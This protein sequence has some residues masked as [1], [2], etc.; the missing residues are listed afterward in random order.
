M[1]ALITASLLLLTTTAVALTPPE[2]EWEKTYSIRLLDVIEAYGN[3]YLCAGWEL[4]TGD[5]NCVFCYNSYGNLL[6]QYNDQVYPR[7]YA[8]ECIRQ[9]PDSTIVA[10][11]T[12]Y[13][14]EGSANAGIS[15]GKLTDSG[16]KIWTKV[17]EIENAKVYGMDFVI[18]PDGGFAV[19]GRIDPSEGMDQ[20]IILRTDAQGDTLWT[21]EWGWVYNDEAMSVLY[22]DNGLTVLIDG[23]ASGSPYEPYLIRYDMDGNLLWETNFPDWPGAPRAQIMCEA[24]DGGLLLMDNYWPTIMHTDYEGNPDWWFW[25]PGSDQPY[26][27]SLSTTMDGGILYG[28]EERGAPTG[29][30]SICG[31]IARYDSLGNGLWSDHVYNSG[32]TAIYSVRQLSHGGY[33]AAGYAY[34]PEN[35]NQAFLIKYAP[36][37]GVESQNLSPSLEISSISPNPFSSVTEIQFS[38]VETGDA[39]LTVYDLNGRVI[40]V[41]GEGVFTEGEHSLQWAPD[42]IASG[43][44][45]VRLTTADNSITGNVV[46]L[47]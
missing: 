15:I 27:H 16:D 42:E 30:K 9:L 8:T 28:G 26:G 13:Q 40:D 5:L 35:G 1:R 38:L 37:L 25:P 17:Y 39:S 34:T 45:L 33:I 21:R 6:W 2:I 41:L 10:V 22:I 31:I 44:Y 23:R 43:C 3:K 12:G 18:L 32:C 36:E 7:I 11:G 4:Q 14:I 47:K 19:C 46:F 29:S 24:S 20:A